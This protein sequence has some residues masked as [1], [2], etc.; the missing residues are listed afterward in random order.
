MDVWSWTK[1]PIASLDLTQILDLRK[2]ILTD[3]DSRREFEDHMQSLE[4]QRSKEQLALNGI[5]HWMTGD[6][7]LALPAAKSISDT[8]VG[9]YIFAECAMFG[10]HLGMDGISYRPEDAANILNALK[11]RTAAHTTM[12]LRAM[13]ESRRIDDAAKVLNNA[14]ETYRSSTDGLY[15]QGLIREEEGDPVEAEAIYDRV[16]NVDPNHTLTLFRRAYKLDLS[17]ADD[18]AIAVYERLID[19]RPPMINALINLGVLY[20][21]NE[22]Y[23]NASRVYRRILSIYPQH[24]RARLYLKDANA[25]LTMYYDEDQEVRNDKK[26]QIL[27]I[28]VSDFE[29]SVR[30]RNCLAKMNIVTLGD[31]VQKTEAELL[32]YKNFGETSLNEIK[33]ILDSKGLRLGMRPEDDLMPVKKSTTTKPTTGPTTGIAIDPNDDRLKK[34]VTELTLSVRSRKC[35]AVLNIKSVADLV[36]YTSEDL[37]SQRNFGVTSLKEISDQ[38]EQIGLSFRTVDKN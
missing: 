15:F 22:Q 18:N 19:Q 2:V 20:E 36:Q 38:L 24:P 4:G 29:L 28:P 37:L 21:D 14:S 16:L 23:Q 25:S 26:N 8:P 3:R 34:S 6:Y 33:L 10:G 13:I 12:L 5:C 35:L 17:G 7:S 11:H 9:A 1:T 31:L 30:S 27:K 32:A